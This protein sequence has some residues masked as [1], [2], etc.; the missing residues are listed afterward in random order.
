M[1][2][3]ASKPSEVCK[4]THSITGLDSVEAL[5]LES[6]RQC[7]GAESNPALVGYIYRRGMNKAKE[8]EEGTLQC[9]LHLSSPQGLI[10]IR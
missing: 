3:E 10:I 5:L 8:E 6:Q 9:N 1:A 2:H 7:V 4:K